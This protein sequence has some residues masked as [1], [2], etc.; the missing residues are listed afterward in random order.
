MKKVYGGLTY[1]G[2]LY[3]D[4]LVACHYRHEDGKVWH[5]AVNLRE[6][7]KEYGYSEEFYK[8]ATSAQTREESKR[9]NEAYRLLLA[10]RVIT[11]RNYTKPV[12]R[13]FVCAETAV[14]VCIT[15]EAIET[16]DKYMAAAKGANMETVRDRVVRLVQQGINGLEYSQIRKAVEIAQN[17]GGEVEVVLDPE[18]V[19]VDDEVFY[20]NGRFGA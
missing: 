14:D 7:C 1:A 18:W 19:L 2:T 5:R 11:E 4:F 10:K 17:S 13:G 16:A 12:E 20:F 3:V 8:N 9:F 6:F 15:H